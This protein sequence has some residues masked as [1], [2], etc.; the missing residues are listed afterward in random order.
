MAKESSLNILTSKGS[1][2]IFLYI[3]NTQTLVLIIIEK[4]IFFVCMMIFGLE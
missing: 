1:S 2:L 4:I 3:N